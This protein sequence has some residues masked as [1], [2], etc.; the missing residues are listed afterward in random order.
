MTTVTITGSG[1]PIVVPGRAG[2]GVL[3]RAAEVA[4]QFDCGRAT[5]LRLS[6]AGQR[7]TDLDALFVTHHHS[8]HLVGLAD[9]LMSRW[10]EASRMNR[11][12][13]LPVV[14]PHGIGSRLVEHTLDPWGE[15][16][17]MRDDHIGYASTP[18]PDVRA[19]TASETAV[20]VWAGSGVTVEAVAVRHEPVE[21]AVGY[22]VTT[23]DATVVISGDTA[24][25]DEIEAL[26]AGADVL[27]HEAFRTG[28]VAGLLS[29]PDAIAAYHADTRELGALAARTGV[30]NLILTHL[31]PPPATETDEQAFVDDVRAGGYEGQILV[32]SDLDTVTVGAQSPR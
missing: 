4:L 22:R 1:T 24:V 16:I 18:D 2:P 15:E 9:L 6:E 30:S 19:F 29:D 12:D 31:I 32:A 8:D 28:A 25:C 21:P 17:A 3:V 23:P 10:L 7:L 27:V 5:S 11:L 13:P 26:A 14:V 20:E